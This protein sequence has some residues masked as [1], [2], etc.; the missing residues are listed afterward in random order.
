MKKEW[1]LVLGLF[2]CLGIVF[3]ANDNQENNSNQMIGGQTDEHG[4]LGPAGYS[5]NETEQQCVREWLQ[6]EERYQ[7]RLN[8][9]LEFLESEEI[10][11]EIEQQLNGVH[12]N[13]TDCKFAKSQNKTKA[14]TKLKNGSNFDIKIMPEVASETALAKLRIKNCNE[15][16]NCTIQ[17]KEVG[18]ENKTRMNY[19]FQAQKTYRFLG[20]FKSNKL[21]SSEI[22]SETGKVVKTNAPWWSFLASEEN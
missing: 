9:E 2:F 18:K 21:V 11:I 1:A 16:N 20:L 6:T 5:W 12:L 17:L 15:S 13:C 14:Y 19:E 4:C 22:D 8:N 10:K 7:D 3:A